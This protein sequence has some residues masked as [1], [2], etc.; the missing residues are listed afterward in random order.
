MLIGLADCVTDACSE[1]VGVFAWSDHAKGGGCACAG[2]DGG[3]TLSSGSVGHSNGRA[4]VTGW[5]RS[6]VAVASAAFETSKVEAIVS[7]RW[8]AV[9]VDRAVRAGSVRDV[10][11]AQA[12]IG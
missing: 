9:A 8:V 7:E 1:W 10:L 4:G 2:S 5:T 11:C 12:H 3:N 6:V